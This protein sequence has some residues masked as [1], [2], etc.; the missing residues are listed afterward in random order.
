M[1]LADATSTDRLGSG[2]DGFALVPGLLM[3][4]RVGAAR[5]GGG[6]FTLIRAG[7]C[8]DSTFFGRSGATPRL[9]AEGGG[10]A[11]P[12]TGARR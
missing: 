1:A 8:E 5:L 3:L 12:R 10:G 7:S 9:A 6:R 4:V 11:W 2:C